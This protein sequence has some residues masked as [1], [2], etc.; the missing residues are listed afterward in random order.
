MSTT[1]PVPLVGVSMYRQTTAW[2]DWERDAALVPGSYL[3]MV[4]DAGG[5]PVPIPPPGGGG[6]GPAGGATPP[7][8]RLV[9]VLDALVLIG[10][11]DIDAARYGRMADHRNGG[12]STQ[13]DELEFGLLAEA[14]RRDLPVLAVCRGLQV[15][16]VG[17]GGDLVQ[18]LPDVLGSH[19][20]QPRPGAFGTVGVVTEEDTTVRRLLGERFDVLCS[21][22]Q[23]ID[24]LGA[25]LVVTARSEDGV[26]EAVELPGR[27]FVVGVQWHPEES[28]DRRLFEALIV[29]ATERRSSGPSVDG[30]R[31]RATR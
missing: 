25:H 18:Q 17:L 27:R 20:H 1:A 19:L 23:A 28:R 16:N 12:A 21:H 7:L 29:A 14:L 5:Q 31:G 2:W 11:G 6:T 26:I 3:D 10:G 30:V 9:G 22:H 4:D 13:R 8:E 15:L 24:S